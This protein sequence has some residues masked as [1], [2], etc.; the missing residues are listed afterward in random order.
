VPAT[1]L[2]GLR[3][4]IFAATRS[5]G[6]SRAAVQRQDDLIVWGIGSH[7]ALASSHHSFDVHAFRSLIAKTAYVSRRPAAKASPQLARRARKGNL[8]ESDVRLPAR[9]ECRWHRLLCGEPHKGTGG[10]YGPLAL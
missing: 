9:L 1:Q 4:V 2:H 10:R 3:A 8:A 5:L 7:P 6:E